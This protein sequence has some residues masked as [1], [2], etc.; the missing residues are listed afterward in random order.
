[1]PWPDQPLAGRPAAVGSVKPSGAPA[2]LQIRRMRIDET[3]PRCA[4]VGTP[5]QPAEPFAAAGPAGADDVRQ[6]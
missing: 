3:S 2:V 5:N 6:R 1:V 4:V